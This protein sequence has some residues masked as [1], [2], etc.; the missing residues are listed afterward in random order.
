MLFGDHLVNLPELFGGSLAMVALEHT[1]R[2]A[3]VLMRTGGRMDASRGAQPKINHYVIAVPITGAYPVA[4]HPTLAH[5]AGRAGSAVAA[6]RKAGL[7]LKVTDTDGDSGID[8]V[9]FFD[10][11]GR[12]P[13]TWAAK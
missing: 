10:G 3:A 7:A 12:T 13:A 8:C 6:A 4:A 1:C 11:A 2:V 5:E 9:T